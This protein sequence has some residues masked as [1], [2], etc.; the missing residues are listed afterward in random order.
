MCILVYL[1][2]RGVAALVARWTASR[3]DGPPPPREDDLV[4]AA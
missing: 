1:V 3:D 2:V 4:L